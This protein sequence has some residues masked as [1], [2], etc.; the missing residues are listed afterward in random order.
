MGKCEV[1]IG[2]TLE[3]PSTL[4][5]FFVPGPQVE[6]KQMCGTAQFAYRP[7]WLVLVRIYQ[8]TYTV[9]LYYFQQ[10]IRMYVRKQYVSG[11]HTTF[12]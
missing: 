8:Y 12:F 4:C 7:G 6:R 2:L 3:K 11:G 10:R 5:S 1:L 9:T